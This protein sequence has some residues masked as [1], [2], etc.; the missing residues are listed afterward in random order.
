M[1]RRIAQVFLPLAAALA[2]GSCTTPT[3]PDSAAPAPPAE[4]AAPAAPVILPVTPVA[5]SSCV[6]PHEREAVEV[7]AV[8]TEAIVGAQSC[9]MTDRFNKF[10]IKFRGE[11]TTEGRALRGFYKKTYGKSGD[12]TLDKFV[13]E[14]SNASFVEGS[15]AFGLCETTTQL[16]DDLMATP[17]GKLA[18]FSAQ[19]PARALPTMESCAG[20]PPKRS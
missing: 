13:T 9:R 11:L 15:A 7:Y 18:A 8:R 5:F 1:H 14:L 2:L 12:A 6:S 19:H 3:A 20:T 4:V 10:A 16:F 17:V